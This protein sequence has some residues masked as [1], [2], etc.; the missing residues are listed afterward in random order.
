MRQDDVLVAPGKG[1]S[2][3]RGIDV[4]YTLSTD[5]LFG[6]IHGGIRRLN[7]C[8]V[9]EERHQS[10]CKISSEAAELK[11][12]ARPEKWFER[13]DDEGMHDVEIETIRVT[14]IPRVFNFGIVITCPIHEL[15][16]LVGAVSAPFGWLIPFVK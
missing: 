15:S 8:D 12:V 7:T 2:F 5:F 14:M 1:Q 9:A 13:A 16:F 11:K 4:A 3:E 10:L 6:F